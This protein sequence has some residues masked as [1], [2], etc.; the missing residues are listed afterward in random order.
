MQEIELKSWILLVISISR[1]YNKH[2]INLQKQEFQQLF[3][4]YKPFKL[5]PKQVEGCI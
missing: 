2:I 1:S 5:H 3:R 4:I